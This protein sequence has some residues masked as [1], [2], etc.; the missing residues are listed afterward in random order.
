MIIGME[1]YLS[2][3]AVTNL[4]MSSFKYFAQKRVNHN[5]KWDSWPSQRVS[6]KFYIT[7]HHN[8]KC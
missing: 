2:V 6:S 3:K 8:M 7:L 5:F 4:H 1:N